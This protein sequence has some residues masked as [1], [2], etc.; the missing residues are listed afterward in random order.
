MKHNA[1]DIFIKTILRKNINFVKKLIFI[2]LTLIAL[3]WWLL[4]SSSCFYGD[5]NL[6]YTKEGDDGEYYLNMYQHLPTT[7]IAVYK[8]ID[9]YDKYFWVLYNKDGKEIW[10]SP[11]YAYLSDDISGMAIPTKKNN[12]LRYSS[13][14]EWEVIDL[15][16]K[17][18]QVNG[19]K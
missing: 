8:L 6:Y 9:G 5:F 10:H 11:H 2:L 12:L 1:I 15:T 16:D 18:N 14:G 19:K 13:N 4:F 3:I 7:P 17:I